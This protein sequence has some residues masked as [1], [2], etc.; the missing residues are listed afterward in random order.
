VK[1][2]QTDAIFLGVAKAF[3]TVWIDGLV[4]KIT[5]LNFPCDIAT[6]CKLTLFVIYLEYYLKDL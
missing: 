2:D 6:S 3:E 5:L 1:G 4:Y